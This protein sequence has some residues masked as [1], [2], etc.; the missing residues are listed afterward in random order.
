MQV[1]LRLC[2]KFTKFQRKLSTSCHDPKI[3]QFLGN[4][5]YVTYS[6]WMEWQVHKQVCLLM[7]LQASLFCLCWSITNSVQ[8]HCTFSFF[9]EQ[10]VTK[11]IVLAYWWK[12]CPT[13]GHSMRQNACPQGHYQCCV[14]IWFLLIAESF[15]SFQNQ[16]T[17]SSG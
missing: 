9:S 14:V 2:Q 4:W 8:L 15:C 16:Q 17:L 13:Q 6:H 1:F 5:A 3:F 10:E 7:S 11:H 12:A